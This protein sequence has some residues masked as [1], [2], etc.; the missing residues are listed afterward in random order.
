MQMELPVEVVL[1]A[2]VV[3]AQAETRVVL[4]LAPAVDL[5]ADV[6]K[7]MD[8]LVVNRSEAEYLLEEELPDRSAMLRGVSVLRELGPAAV[9]L[10]TGAE[11]AVFAHGAGVTHVPAVPVEVV[12]TSGAG[13]AFVGVLAAGLSRGHTLHEAAIAA[14][15]A[16]AAAVQSR[17]AQLTSLVMQEAK[18]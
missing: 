4:N 15:Q 7:R 17:G 10:T 14:T 16:A 6:F 9:V 11:G 3:A 18:G 1:R 13:D 2:L 12:D 8:V 5:P